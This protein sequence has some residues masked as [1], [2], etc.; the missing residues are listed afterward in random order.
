ML[1]RFFRHDEPGLTSDQI[2]DEYYAA[3][4]AG[5]TSEELAEIDARHA[6]AT[7]AERR[8][9]DQRIGDPATLPGLL[10]AY[11]ARRAQLEE[12]KCRKAA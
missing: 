1:R 3:K 10:G 2:A 11:R 5:A 6:A 4:D 7:A 12:D 9:L 8:Y